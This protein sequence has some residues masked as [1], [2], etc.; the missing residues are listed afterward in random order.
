MQN[1]LNPIADMYQSQ[2]EVSRQFSN[3]IFSGVGKIDRVVIE[4][5]HHAVDEQLRMAQSVATARDPSGAASAQSR[6][7]TKPSGVMPYQQEVMRIFAE[8][9]NEI[10]RAMKKYLEKIRNN[11]SHTATAPF[12]AAQQRATDTVVNPMTGV[13]SMWESA[14]RDVTAMADKNMAAGRSAFD[15]TTT[16]AREAAAKAVDDI[17]DVVATQVNPSGSNVVGGSEQ[18][19]DNHQ[20]VSGNRS[21]SGKADVASDG[22]FSSDEKRTGPSVNKRK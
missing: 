21:E 15:A 11:M 8:M 4:A 7:F 9:Q 16:A 13:F 19:S 17:T 10:G 22:E 3:I 20:S 6:F 18:G 1:V 12:Q 14:F 5:T 2:L